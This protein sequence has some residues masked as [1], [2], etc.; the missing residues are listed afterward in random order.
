[1]ESTNYFQLL[2]RL[3]PSSTLLPYYG[4]YI[5]IH[6]LMTY[7]CTST[8]ESWENYGR[9]Y[10]D[11][12]CLQKHPLKIKKFTNKIRKFLAEEDRFVHLILDIRIK[13]EEHFIEFIE[14]LKQ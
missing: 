10:K 11:T 12:L 1:M 8:K 13:E 9:K 6:T 2:L 7:L 4:S 14:F 3:G 5:E